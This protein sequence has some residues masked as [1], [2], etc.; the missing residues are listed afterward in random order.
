MSQHGATTPPADHPQ[1]DR[2][3]LEYVGLEVAEAMDAVRRLVDTA[4]YAGVVEGR[5]GEPDVVQMRQMLAR[6]DAAWTY[7]LEI[8]RRPL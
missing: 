5:L 6:L 2:L 7:A 3:A 8:A 1:L 4:I